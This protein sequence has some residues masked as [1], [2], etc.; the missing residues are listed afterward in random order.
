MKKND[1]VGGTDSE[2]TLIDWKLLINVMLVGAV[3]VPGALI[4]WPFIRWSDAMSLILRVVP[5]LA[6][7]ILLYRIGKWRIIKV[8]PTL[9][10]GAFAVRGIFLFSFS[11][12][13]SEATLRGLIADYVSPF[14]AC[15]IA[16]SACVLIKNRLKNAGQEIV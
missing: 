10:A 6:M 1:L 14:I 9:I 3:I 15:V 2:S 11:S 12:H 16:L 8:L 4:F 13:W 5:S 7:Q